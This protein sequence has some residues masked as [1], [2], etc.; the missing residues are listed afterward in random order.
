MIKNSILITIISVWLSACISTQTSD[1]S[2]DVI[3][4]NGKNIYTV[5][6]EQL[7]MRG[8]N[9]MFIW[10]DDT[11]GE[12]TIPQIAKTGSNTLRIVWLT[13]N[14]NDKATP[15]NLDRIIQNTADNGMFPMP[16]LHG[17]TGKWEKLNEQVDY[18]TDSAI[19]AVLKKHE[20]YLLLNIANECGDHG[21]DAETFT[22][23]Y[24]HA[25]DRIRATGLRCPLVIDASGWGQ[26]LEILLA[27]GPKLL[28]HDPLQNLIFS[29]HMWWVAD[30]GST[31]RI[32]EGFER[33]V[34]LDLPIIVGEFAPMGVGCARSIDYETIMEQCEKHQIGWLAWSWGKVRNGDCPEMDMTQGEHRGMFEGLT[35]WGLEVAV[36]HPFSIQNTAAKPRIK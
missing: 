14:E 35:D 6:G 18:W 10:S 25:I 2:S 16:E 4:V 9:E 20:S 26:D 31:Q 27:T 34:A 7:V 24:K 17:A 29:V 33:S 5:F 21:I 8:V 36:T 3:R 19:V 12:I 30:D 22:E 13:N 1:P 32:V 11:T 23:G 28:A 15:E